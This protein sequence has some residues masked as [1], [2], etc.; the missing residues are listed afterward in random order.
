M[1]VSEQALELRVEFFVVANTLE[2]MLLRHPLDSENHERHAKRAVGQ[3]G[4]SDFLSRTDRFA[5]RYETR[6]ELFRK[7]LEQ[8]NVLGFFPGELQERARAIVV[9]IQMRPHVIE[10]ERQ[11]ELLDDAERVEISV[12]ANLVEQDLLFR[13]EKS[14]RLHPGQRLGHERFCEIEAF[15]AA[16][17]VFNAP[18]GPHRRPQS[19]LVG[20][21]GCEHDASFGLSLQNIAALPR[22]K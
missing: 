22:Y 17:D 10:H 16:D 13:V 21:I 7:L 9:F 5:V 14:Q 19:F 15:V 6:L 3:H 1:L 20:V 11:N 8:M 12:A 4:L 18:V 2:I